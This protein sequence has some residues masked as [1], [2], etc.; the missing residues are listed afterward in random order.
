M[1]FAHHYNSKGFCL[2]LQPN[3]VG[4]TDCNGIMKGNAALLRYAGMSNPG[5]FTVTDGTG[6]HER[7][8][9]CGGPNLKTVFFIPVKIIEIDLQILHLNF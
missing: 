2:R 6:E 1:K 9:N 5:M 8:Y 7:N 4:A 3:R